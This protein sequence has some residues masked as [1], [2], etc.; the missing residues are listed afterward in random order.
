M[1]WISII[2]SV[3]VLLGLA[4]VNEG[5]VANSMKAENREGLILYGILSCSIGSVWLAIHGLTLMLRRE[6]RKDLRDV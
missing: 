4:M 1:K 2:A 6:S 3:I 5:R